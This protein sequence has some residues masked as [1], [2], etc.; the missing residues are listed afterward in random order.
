MAIFYFQEGGHPPSW[1]FKKI[2]NFNG[3]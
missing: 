1:I 2:L 3:Q